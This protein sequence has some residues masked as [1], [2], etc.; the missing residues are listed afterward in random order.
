MAVKEDMRRRVS[1]GIIHSRARMDRRG[2]I[3]MIGGVEVDRGLWRLVWRLWRVVV[4]WIVC[5]SRGA[6]L[7][8]GARWGQKVGWEDGL[9]NMVKR[10]L[11]QD[12]WALYIRDE[13]LK[14][15]LLSD[16]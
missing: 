10:Q 11:R 1:R 2:V 8:D 14:A 6:Q 15:S 13:N 16:G 7:D 9:G 12:G 3:M 5:C 4:V